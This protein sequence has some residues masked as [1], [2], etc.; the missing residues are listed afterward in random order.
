MS[1]TCFFANNRALIKLHEQHQSC[2]AQTLLDCSFQL[3][4]R[5]RFVS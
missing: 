5:T 3:G 4:E 2:F 1:A